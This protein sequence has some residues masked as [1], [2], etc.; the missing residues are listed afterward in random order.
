[1]M[2]ANRVLFT[3]SAIIRLIISSMGIFLFSMVFVLQ[4]VVSE[5][6][7]EGMEP[8]N[9]FIHTLVSA[10]PQTYGYLLNYNDQ[11][12]VDYMMGFAKALFGVLLVIAIVWFIFGIINLLLS[13]KCK[14]GIEISLGKKIAIGIL[15][16]ILSGGFLCNVLTTFALFLKKKD[17]DGKLYN[18]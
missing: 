18:N 3:I 4:D 11:Q 12:C 13:K 9:E 1:M 2:K 7:L 15:S 14:Y 5:A 6:M 16:W 10:D 17:S 8:V